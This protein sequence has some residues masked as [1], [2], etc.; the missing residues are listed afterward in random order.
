M[1][2]CEGELAFEV[3]DAVTHAI[4]MAERLVERH[5]KPGAIH[6]LELAAPADKATVQPWTA[7]EQD[8]NAR[9]RAKVRTTTLLGSADG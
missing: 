7:L 1:V 2:L 6:L 4:M 8:L 5:T 3:T 9:H